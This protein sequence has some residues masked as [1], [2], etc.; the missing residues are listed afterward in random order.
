MRL[1]NLLHIIDQEAIQNRMKTLPVSLT[2]L[3][4]CVDVVDVFLL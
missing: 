1:L 3:E 2:L 4:F